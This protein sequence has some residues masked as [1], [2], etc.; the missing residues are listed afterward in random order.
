MA[1]E[2]EREQWG[3]ELGAVWARRQADLDRMMTR[4]TALLVDRA[5]VAPG[6]RVLDV[7]C[8][9]GDSTLA[10]ARATGPDGHATGQDVSAPLLALAW[11]RAEAAGLANVTLVEGDAQTDRASG[12][13]F[14]AMLSRFGVMFFADPVAAFAN[15]ASQLRPG[16][17]LTFVAWAAAALYP[18]LARPAA[19]AA[20][21]LGPASPADPDAPGLDGPPPPG[22][23]A[24]ARPEAAGLANVTLVE[25][26][27]QTD[28]AP[29]GPFDAMLSRFGVMFF[30]DPVAAFANVAS[31]LR[32]GAPLT[33]VAWAA[34]AQNPW[35]ARPAAAAA[36]RLGPASPADPDAPGPTAFRDPARVTGL[37]ARAGLRDVGAE[38]CDVELHHPGG[39]AALADLGV[40]VG[41]AASC[42]R[43]CAGTADDRQAVAGAI[44]EAFAE[45]ASPD[46]VRIPA[47]VLVYSARAA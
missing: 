30:A 32:P 4:L 23:G 40:E 10:A 18:W 7:G 12:G 33:F 35:L 29:G 8:G 22:A 5:Q 31:Q 6:A 36:A 14:D 16:A 47:R 1:N 38:V 26:D 24:R 37:L 3:G 46:G 2:D 15:I 11:A 20:A 34:A 13:P 45:F 28:R 25:G 19:A 42:L 43:R 39:P 44:E 27:A 9:A 21:R 41:P 17:P